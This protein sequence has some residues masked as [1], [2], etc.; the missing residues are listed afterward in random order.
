MNL[1]AAASGPGSF[2]GLRVGLTTIKALAEVYTKPIAAV[3]RLEVLA[4]LGVTKTEWIAATADAGRG[5]V[6]GALYG[7][8]EGELVLNGET[9]VAE[10]N[11]FIADVAEKCGAQMVGWVT[12]DPDSIRST[13]AW[14][15]RE[16]AGE[17][18][19][20]VTHPL[21]QQIGRIGSRK[22]ARGQV[23]TPG[24]LEADYV[25]RSDAEIFW[26]GGAR[27]AGHRG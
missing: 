3:S 13:P 19:Q 1:Y 6:F 9:I 18:L 27:S 7:R 22:A 24:D 25:R 16:S 10:P 8:R 21:A 26:K 5:Q 12:L 23:L 2:T 20:H 11:E 15:A 4:S 14:H 17:S